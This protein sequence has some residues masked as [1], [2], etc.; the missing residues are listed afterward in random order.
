VSQ[1]GVERGSKFVMV[2]K[3][4]SRVTD[5]DTRIMDKAQARKI[6]SNESGMNTNHFSIFNNFLSSHFVNVAQ[7]CGIQIGNDEASMADVIN[8]MVAQKKAHAMLN[9]AKIR[10]DGEL[11]MEKKKNK[12]LVNIEGDTEG[13][14]KR[15]EMRR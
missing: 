1:V 5:K 13:V 10:R 2:E 11:H 6:K 4:S 14:T 7:S 12:H 3:H 8:T 15:G 9:E